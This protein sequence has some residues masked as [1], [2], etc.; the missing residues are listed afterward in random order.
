MRTQSGAANFLWKLTAYAALVSVFAIATLIAPSLWKV[1]PACLLGAMFAHGIELEHELIH[2][3]HFNPSLQRTMGFL[4]G[5]PMLVEFSRYTI[6]H[7][8]H[9]RMVGTAEDEESFAYDFDRL[10]SPVGLLL[11]LSMVD[12]YRYVLNRIGLA[13]WGKRDRMKQDLGKAGTHLP[14]HLL[15]QIMGGY[16]VFAGVLAIALILSFAFKT[17]AFAQ[18]WLL[19]LI[20]ASPIHALVELPEHWGCTHIQADCLE[21]T[22][23]I[24]PSR[25]MEWF[26]N[27]N[28]WHV[29]HH[30]NP[31]VPIEQLSTFHDQLSPRIKFMNNGYGA[32]YAEFFQAMFRKQ[33]K[34]L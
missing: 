3:K 7:G 12:H 4:L 11:H 17:T 25:F 33:V 24:L 16:R 1:L 21:N 18:I 29:E 13:C 9:H 28:C 6:T 32:F 27:G 34:C 20:F 19:P 31:A 22:R 23:T 26:T 2:Q 5:L 14:T 8:Y 10:H 15:N 30:Y